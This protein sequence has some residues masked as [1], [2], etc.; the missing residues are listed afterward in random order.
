M[1]L[2]GAQIL[3][4]MIKAEGIDTIFG[5]PGGCVIDIYD[6]LAK[7]EGLRHILVR[8][9]QGA[10]HS[11]DGFARANKSVGVALVTSGPGATNAVTGIASAHSDS[12]PIVVFTGQVPTALI[13]NDAF[14]EVDIVGITRPCTKH[15][16]L[17]K[18]IDKL[19]S[20]IKEAFYLARSG[21]PGPVLV[22]LPK[23]ILQAQI[24]FEEPGE[25]SLKS[26]KP[27]YKPN[28]K[29]L[30]KVVEMIKK[31]ERPVIFAGG[32]VIVSQASEQITRLAKMADIPV[33]ASLMGLGAFPGSDPLWLG[34]LGMHG[35]YRANMS[36]GHCDLMI[37]AGV[38]FDDR[39]TGNIEKFAPTAK[40]IQ[41]DIDPTSI[42]KNIE[43]HCPIV[44]DC[45]AALEGI[46][47][48]MK[49]QKTDDLKNNRPQWLDQIAEWKSTTPLK[50]NQGSEVIKPQFVVEKLYELTKGDAIITTEVGQNQ[51]WAAQYYHFNKPNHFITSGGLGTMG[52]GLPAAI[53]AKAAC[54]DKLVVDVAGDGSIQMNIQELMTAVESKIDVKIVILN[55]QYLGMVRQ[56][57]EL[58]YEKVYSFTDM[59]NTPDFVKLAE[60]YGAKG[61]RCTRPDEVESVL[62]Q[63]LNHEGTVIMEFAVDKEESVYPMVP[64]GGSN[65]E[66]LLV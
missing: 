24:D 15:N 5:Y 48:L 63:G 26:Y 7:Q 8:H 28:K 4:K 1:K 29:Q 27:N 51:M 64:A 55:N 59:E 66:M 35:T 57:Q 36:I 61:L 17:V 21:R 53:G 50:Y 46:L 23:N 2:N 16:Y 38:R 19:A 58:F 31:A 39:V 33:T 3:I 30:N 14:Q 32:G 60:A 10:V 18:S 22:D 25:I 6:E 34:M 52:F 41:I 45:K 12:I 54:P 11:A 40:I 13:G 49:D 20:T 37:A 47:H 65:T 62:S 56:W 42:H 43:V 44:G 9:E